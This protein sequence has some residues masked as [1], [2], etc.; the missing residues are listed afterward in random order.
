MRIEPSWGQL[1]D[2]A[3]LKSSFCANGECVE[4]TRKGDLVLMRSS[5]EPQ[6]IVSYSLEDWQLF[7]QRVKSGHFSDLA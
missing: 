5:N 1:S 4:V 2:G 7:L 6:T 3:W